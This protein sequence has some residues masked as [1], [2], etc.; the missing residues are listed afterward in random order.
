MFTLLRSLSFPSSHSA[1]TQPKSIIS[2]NAILCSVASVQFSSVTSDSLQT[3]G[4]QHTRPPCPSPTP[5][6]HSAAYSLP[7]A[8][9]ILW[10][11]FKSTAGNS[12]PAISYTIIAHLHLSLYNL[13]IPEYCISSM[14][15]TMNHICFCPLRFLCCSLIN[16]DLTDPYLRHS[17]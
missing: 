16:Y 7:E 5:R 15:I 9:H 6:V 11:K 2:Q 3:H 10:D 14:P 13:E 4:L 12:N 1:F 8:T 17:S